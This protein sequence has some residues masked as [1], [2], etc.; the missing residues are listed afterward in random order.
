[1]SENPSFLVQVAIWIKDI[2]RLK[3]GI[4][5]V[6]QSTIGQAI[7]IDILEVHKSKNIATGKTSEAITPYHFFNYFNFFGF[8]C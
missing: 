2:T 7:K 4:V 3:E 1:M 8:Y 5:C 6:L